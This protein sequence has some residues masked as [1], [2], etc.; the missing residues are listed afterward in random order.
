MSEDQ[1]KQALAT[2]VQSEA[3][4]AE[5]DS[6]M[7]G[8]MDGSVPPALAVMMDEGVFSRVSAIAQRMAGARSIVP[9]HLIDNPSGCFA[10]VMRSLSWRLDPFAVAQATFDIGGKL[11]YEGKLCH[12]ILENSGKVV[13]QIRYRHFGKVWLKNKES[14]D[15]F[16]DVKTN[17]PG[18]EELIRSGEWIETRR[19]TWEGL[20]GKFEIRDSQRKE[21]NSTEPKKYAAPTY[22]R[23]DEEGLGVVVQADIRGEAEPRAFEFLMIQ[24]YPRNSTIWATD[25]KTQ[26]CY[27]AIRRFASVAA[28]SLV[29]GIPFDREEMEGGIREV[30]ER[31]APT[32]ARPTRGDFSNAGPTTIDVEQPAAEEQQ[33][34]VAEVEPQQEQQGQPADA[35]ADEPE[36]RWGLID[37][38]GTE[39]ENFAKDKDGTV[40][41]VNALA[42]RYKAMKDPKHLDT[43]IENTP[44]DALPEDAQKYLRDVHAEHAKALGG[45]PK[46][47][48]AGDKGQG[49]LGV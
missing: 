8:I 13:G 3:K 16:I 27:T 15:V 34:T 38:T 32:T 17:D 45:K 28:P 6:L 37:E 42:I 5:T 11:G 22:T 36:E 19:T 25:P 31:P 44:M 18:L 29:M 20:I 7:R 30:N 40:A 9:K 26:I 35:V 24:A 12:A 33:E 10:V 2:A 4:T 49:G 43:L 14:P 1:R 23:K 46:A 47:K 41:F 21:A 39:V 48:A